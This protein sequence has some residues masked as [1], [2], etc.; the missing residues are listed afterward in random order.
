MFSHFFALSNNFSGCSFCGVPTICLQPTTKTP[1]PPSK[2]Y[3]PYVPWFTLMP[4]VFVPPCK[5]HWSSPHCNS[6]GGMHWAANTGW[7]GKRPRR[8]LCGRM[9]LVLGCPA[10]KITEASSGGLLWCVTMPLHTGIAST[11]G[12]LLWRP[13]RVL[14]CEVTNYNPPKGGHFHH[15]NREEVET[16]AGQKWQPNG[17]PEEVHWGRDKN[18]KA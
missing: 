15:T 3:C 1:S 12:T 14:K 17:Q 6:T 18:K 8:I 9:P 7:I 5:M 10:C 16:V 13:H 2:C 4:R 11:W